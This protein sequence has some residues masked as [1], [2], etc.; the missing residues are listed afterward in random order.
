MYIYMKVR[1][2][3]EY[4]CVDSWLFEKVGCA[5]LLYHSN[6]GDVFEQTR[7]EHHGFSTKISKTTGN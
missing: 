6:S 4:M 3:S 5:T 7:H 2:D 1:T